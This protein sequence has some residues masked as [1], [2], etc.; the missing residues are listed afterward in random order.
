MGSNSGTT[1]PEAPGQV[2]DPPE[3]AQVANEDPAISFDPER[4]HA[5]VHGEHVRVEGRRHRLQESSP[6]FEGPAEGNV[7]RG[8]EVGVGYDLRY[9][10]RPDEEQ[11]QFLVCR[12]CEIQVAP[13]SYNT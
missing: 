8:A 3:R 9:L 12:E 11:D 6:V 13:A 4:R 10:P 1:A 5:A 2:E 7:P